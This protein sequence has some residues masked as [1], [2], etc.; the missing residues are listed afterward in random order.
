MPQRQYLSV[1]RIHRIQYFLH[2]DPPLR[3]DGGLA[4]SGEPAE[5]LGRQGRAARRW[6]RALRQRDLTACIPC[7]GA[8]V[9][10]M[11]LREPLAS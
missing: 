4:R 6:Q 3:P 7:P 2:P 8:Q 9:D 1:D 10:A 11:L 5:Q